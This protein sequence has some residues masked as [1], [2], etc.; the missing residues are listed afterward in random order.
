M[1]EK[2]FTL[3]D[4]NLVFW[5]ELYGN[6]DEAFLCTNWMVL[7]KLIIFYST[8][9]VMCFFVNILWKLFIIILANFFT[10]R[11]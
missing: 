5:S 3:L 9:T 8:W 11:S 4:S 2:C 6:S 1:S 10:S 7:N